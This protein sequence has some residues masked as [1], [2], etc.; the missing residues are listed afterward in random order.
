MTVLCFSFVSVTVFAEADESQ[1]SASKNQHEQT[2][3]LRSVMLNLKSMETKFKQLQ[4]DYDALR[5]KSQKQQ[6]ESEE[7]SK[8]AED[9]ARKSQQEKVS[10]IQALKGKIAFNLR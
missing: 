1:I 8:K 3:K 5:L 10:E 4:D 9:A 6:A 2:S 7:L